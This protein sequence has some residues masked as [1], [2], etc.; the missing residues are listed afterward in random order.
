MNLQDLTNVH[1]RW[2][3]QRIQYNI[4]W[5]TIWQEWHIFYRKNAG[6]DTLVT[7]TTSHLIADLNLT[8][9]CNVNTNRFI[10]SRWKL[11][12]ILSCKYFGI[13][14]NTKLTMWHFQRSITNFS[15][16]LTEDCTKQSFLSSKLCLSLR[17]NF[18]NQNITGTNLCTD[19][20]NTVLV[21]VF[22]RVVAD[23]RYITG[24]LFVTKLGVSRLC[25][26]LIDMN[27][28]INIILNQSLTKQYGI[29][30]VIT[31]P[32]H[33]TDQWVLT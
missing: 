21:K 27:R 30:V 26:V 10:Y 25:I 15:C 13:Y 3:T 19:T 23:T 24:D 28:C 4:K 18:T 16:F 9:L 5:T 32:S 31:F 8:F 29:L 22:E 11:I 20:D 17:S 33:E 7:M 1:T 6:N 14:D 2:H 12:S